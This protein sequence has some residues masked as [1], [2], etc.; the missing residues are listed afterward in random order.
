MK[1]KA[2][3]MPR[4]DLLDLLFDCFKEYKYWTLASLKERLVQPESYLRDTL[5]SIA[6]LI[7]SGPMIGKYQLR[8]ESTAERFDTGT[9]D[10]VNV[11]AEAAPDADPNAPDLT[12]DFED[13]EMEDVLI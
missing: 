4:N 10:N 5:D 3:R 6:L 2:A 9:F 1:E 8:P 12:D 13:E 7:R 11:K